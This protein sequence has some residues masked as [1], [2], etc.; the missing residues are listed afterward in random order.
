MQGVKDEVLKKNL[1]IAIAGQKDVL[2][3]F[4][5]KGL[6]FNRNM[7]DKEGKELDVNNSKDVKDFGLNAKAQEFTTHHGSEEFIKKRMQFDR[8]LKD[9]DDEELDVG[10]KDGKVRN[11]PSIV[12]GI[13]L[14][15]FGIKDEDPAG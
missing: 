7:Q 13:Q 3:K 15:R 9:K 6:Q 12:I 8:H 14:D 2:K 4:I 5:N 10:N 11:R 1:A